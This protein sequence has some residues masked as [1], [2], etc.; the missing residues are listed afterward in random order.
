[1]QPWSDARAI[2]D[3]AADAVNVDHGFQ[4][5]WYLLTY[6]HQLGL[7]FPY[8]LFT[9][10]LGETPSTSSRP[11]ACWPSSAFLGPPTG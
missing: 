2:L 7:F 5:K 1:M 9:L 11:S 3:V 10:L 4:P 8:T 6:P